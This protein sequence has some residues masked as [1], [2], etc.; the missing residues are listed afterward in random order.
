MQAG[1]AAGVVS[2]TNGGILT[3]AVNDVASGG[4][5]YFSAA[6]NDGNRDDGTSSVWEGD[7]V[8]GGSAGPVFG[9]PGRL[10]DFGGGTT[11]ETLTA[12][13][14]VVSLFWADPLGGSVNDYDLFVLDFS[15]STV[16]ASSTNFQTGSQDPNEEIAG[17]FNGCLLYTSDAA[18]E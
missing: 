14:L 17:S 11:Y 9:E 7:F 10:H 8:D 5:L 4:V 2:N 6:G 12:D 18:D 1:Q 3:Q 16:L 15:G 13:S